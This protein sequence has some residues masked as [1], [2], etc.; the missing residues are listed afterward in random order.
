MCLLAIHAGCST[1]RLRRASP[2]AKELQPSPSPYCVGPLPCPLT[3]G[4]PE[5]PKEVKAYKATS[6]Q[7]PSQKISSQHLRSLTP[8]PARGK[9]RPPIC[10]PIW[11][12]GPAPC[13][14]RTPAMRPNG[15]TGHYLRRHRL[16]P[17]Q[18][19]SSREHA[20]ERSTLLEKACRTFAR[21]PREP[22][23]RCIGSSLDRP[24]SS[25]VPRS[26]LASRPGP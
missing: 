4:F 21:T 23:L 25:S 1:G 22:L 17:A 6:T 12:P 10:Q 11:P 24:G 18:R 26:A 9:A 2:S 13:T 7:N 19:C 3:A 20:L 15:K 8:S 14:L 16:C 5:K